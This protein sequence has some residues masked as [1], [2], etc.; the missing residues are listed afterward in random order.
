MQ[1]RAGV[2]G[3]LERGA[4]AGNSCLVSPAAAAPVQTWRTVVACTL[5]RA[6]H[7]VSA[8]FSRETGL[9]GWP[10]KCQ[11]PPSVQPQSGGGAQYAAP[12][13][14]RRDRGTGAGRR[15]AGKEPSETASTAPHP[16]EAAALHTVAAD[17]H[18][19]L[20][21][22]PTSLRPAA[23][24]NRD[25]WGRIAVAAHLRST[26]LRCVAAACACLQAQALAPWRESRGT[27]QPCS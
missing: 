24:V 19:M 13:H 17:V 10:L 25:V 1:G 2:K 20:P 23:Q 22:A 18:A 16:P 15:L 5:R 14:A 8:A 11:S 6:G 21:L 12:K 4:R 7:H 26:G 9:A 27:Q 3:R